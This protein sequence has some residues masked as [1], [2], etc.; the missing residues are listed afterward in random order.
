MKSSVIIGIGI[1]IIFV[2]IITI[3]S[4]YQKGVPKDCEVS[5]WISEECDPISGVLTRKRVILLEAENGGK[6][7]PPLQEEF[8]ES[9]K[10]DCRVGE[11]KEGECDRTKGTK[12]FTRE[13]IA[14]PIKGG[15][16]C[17]VLTKEI[18]CTRD[19]QYGEEKRDCINGDLIKTRQIYVSDRLGGNPCPKSRIV[20]LNACEKDCVLNQWG[21]WNENRQTG[22]KTRTRTVQVEAQ[23]GGSCD[24][25]LVETELGPKD[26]ETGPWSDWICDRVN[27]QMKK[28]RQMIKPAERG[29]SCV[30]EDYKC[31]GQIRG[32]LDE[33]TC[34]I[35]L[36]AKDC[37]C[38]WTQ[39]DCDRSVGKDKRTSTGILEPAER[40]GSCE[41]TQYRENANCPV[42]CN[43]TIISDTCNRQLG[44]R[45]IIRN[46][47]V[48]PEKGGI[49]CPGTVTL[50]TTDR[51]ETT[52]MIQNGC[53]RDCNF[54]TVVNN[55]DVDTGISDEIRY[56][57][58]IGEYDGNPSNGGNACPVLNTS[59]KANC[60]KA[61]NGYGLLLPGTD[62]CSC[63]Y[64]VRS[65]D[66]KNCIRSYFTIYDKYGNRVYRIPYVGR[67]IISASQY[68]DISATFRDIQNL[69]FYN[70]KYKG[71]LGIFELSL[72]YY[73]NNNLMS[74]NRK[75]YFYN[76]YRKLENNQQLLYMD[77]YN[78]DI[79]VDE[80]F[81]NYINRVRST[82]LSNPLTK[83]TLTTNYN[84]TIYSIDLKK[85]TIYDNNGTL[86]FNLNCDVYI[87]NS[88]ANTN[89][90][91]LISEEQTYVTG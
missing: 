10:R 75:E 60:P 84:S 34:I 45:K 35:E 2:I 80:L 23:N 55:C 39:W 1:I 7:C 33:P 30:L 81:S 90:V 8:K 50:N 47:T 64:S 76:I 12:T 25:N 86:K 44:E 71:I 15:I 70:I 6:E 36:C 52:Q 83:I 63:Y 9:C 54:R 42:D 31:N 41:Q 48:R 24:Y 61:C 62:E 11:W 88:K 78:Y 89:D 27:G 37:K 29:G 20:E 40:G 13:I 4:K 58:P 56:L 68:I 79:N 53:P 16:Q 28:T 87:N 17:P 51:M 5:D 18:E 19:C 38:Q 59:Y 57:Q 74:Q 66:R 73:M 22:I 85:G 65:S 77:F 3:F 32:K 46:I 82:F 72:K 43:S 49:P 26:C 91:Q 69:D 67:Y 21:N 14:G